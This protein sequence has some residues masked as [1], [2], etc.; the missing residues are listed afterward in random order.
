MNFRALVVL[1]FL[2]QAAA[3]LG[4]T[5][6][7]QMNL[8]IATPPYQ[9]VWGY[10]LVR[11]NSTSG[12]PN[13]TVL[14]QGSGFTDAWVK[15]LALDKAVFD[16]EINSS[17]A[18]RQGQVLSKY[19]Y[20]PVCPPSDYC[21]PSCIGTRYEYAG[22]TGRFTLFA[23]GQLQGSNAIQGY[24]IPDTA[25]QLNLNAQLNVDTRCR[26]YKLRLRVDPNTGLRY[27]NE[28]YFGVVTFSG[29]VSDKAAYGLF[30]LKPQANV[31][32][33]RIA[34]DVSEISRG[35]LTVRTAAP[36]SNLTFILGN[37]SLSYSGNAYDVGYY[38]PDY[39][40]LRV[41]TYGL[42][43]ITQYGLF[44]NVS[45]ARENGSG[46]VVT[47]VDFTLTYGETKALLQR[48]ICRLIV[49]DL[50]KRQY[51]LENLC[52]TDWKQPVI[53]A[54]TNGRIFADNGEVNISVSLAY[55]GTQIPGRRVFVRYANR[56][57]AKTTDSNGK[58]DFVFNAEYPNNRVEVEF[59]GDGVYLGC[60]K[61]V[62]IAVSDSEV[63]DLLAQILPA[64][65]VFVISVYGAYRMLKF[66]GL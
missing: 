36:Y 28:R 20:T 62:L 30:D 53:D 32:F 64:F 55:N 59:P 54:S 39:N 15:I 50:F 57:Y 11:G 31:S 33:Q 49:E 43:R 34:Q 5:N 24:S 3:A 27:C 35:R 47:D 23:N 1:V 29:V 37:N 13:G 16:S 17:Y 7:P 38:L 58:A 22:S 25:T 52:P 41:S 19:G 42:S 44:S 9:V 2:S 10:N 45:R 65:L 8:T 66:W 51:V 18:S 40:L 14:S 12:P 61:T 48:R 4:Y 60:S 63:K 46:V 6:L 56:Q 26:K 21:W